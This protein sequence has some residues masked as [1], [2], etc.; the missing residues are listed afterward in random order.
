MPPRIH[1]TSCDTLTFPY[2]LST[3]P[4]ARLVY[5]LLRGG[6]RCFS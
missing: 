2:R 1:I 4:N 5:A 6:A 3:L